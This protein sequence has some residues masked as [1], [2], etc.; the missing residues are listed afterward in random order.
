MECEVQDLLSIRLRQIYLIQGS[1]QPFWRA[2]YQPQ[3]KKGVGAGVKS[4][5]IG[6]KTWKFGLKTWKFG[7]NT[8]KIGQE[9]WFIGLET[10]F[11]GHKLDWLE[12]RVFVGLETNFSNKEPELF[13][14]DLYSYSS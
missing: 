14:I 6:L 4:W 3:I 11:F 9:N 8:W 12:M 10:W 1:S 13:Y 5:K 2:D 7:L